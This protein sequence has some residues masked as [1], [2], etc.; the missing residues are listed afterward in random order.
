MLIR[1][2]TA[3]NWSEISSGI[4]LEFGLKLHDFN[5]LAFSTLILLLVSILGERGHNVRQLI[6]SRPLPL[7]W[8]ILMAFMYITLAFFMTTGGGSADF[9]YA[10]F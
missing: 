4:L 6:F 8:L 2:F 1:S 5:V 10:V 3:F 7:R 9:L